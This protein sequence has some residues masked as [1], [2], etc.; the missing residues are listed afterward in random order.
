MRR[1]GWYSFLFTLESTDMLVG[2]WLVTYTV[3]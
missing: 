1:F 3:E 2:V